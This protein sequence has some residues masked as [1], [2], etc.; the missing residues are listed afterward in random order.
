MELS[1]Y[2]LA[3]YIASYAAA[4]GRIDAIVFTG[5]IGENSDVIRSIVLKQLSIFGIEVDEAANTA[6]RFG[7]EG[8]ITTANSKIKAMV[9]STNEELVI[10]QDAVSLI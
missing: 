4:L 2:R 1:C 3:K 10:A 7:S 5:G 8:T 9:I 6:A